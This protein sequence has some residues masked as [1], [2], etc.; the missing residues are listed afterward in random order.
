MG[1]QSSTERASRR[2][3]PGW[4]GGFAAEEWPGLLQRPPLQGQPRL[5]L[6]GLQRDGPGHVLP[7]GPI[8]AQPWPGSSALPSPSRQPF[9][10]SSEPAPLGSRFLLFLCLC[11][12]SP[13]PGL[14]QTIKDHITKPTAM[15]QGR[16]AHLIEWKGWRASQAGWDPTL[17]G[18]ELYADLTDEL[19][20]ARFAA[21]VAEQFAITEATLSAW[22]S[23][24]ERE[25]D[26]GGATQEVVQ[27]QDLE[28]IYLQG[29]VLWG[30]EGTGG[31]HVTESLPVF[32][33][34]GQESPVPNG[35]VWPRW[36]ELP[37]SARG[38]Q[39]EEESMPGSLWL[40]RSNTSLRYVDSSSVSED[41]VFYN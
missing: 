8:L 35:H 6:R 7:G 38:E 20:E 28:S 36:G 21:G 9:H 17:T 29:N 39:Q 41:D 34:S 25:M 27:L 15:A 14:V 24:E 3:G 30:S 26:Y 11:R 10:A 40:W 23:L 33:P 18:E 31:P 19:K 32:S 1:C 22:S 37:P 5:L 12:R 13:P 2:P 4:P 16:V